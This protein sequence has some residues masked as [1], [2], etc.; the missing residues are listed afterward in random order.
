MRRR[1]RPLEAL[2]A[3]VGLQVFQVLVQI[4]FAYSF[5][6]KE[7]VYRYVW[8][9]ISI[10]SLICVLDVNIVL[11]LSESFLRRLLQNWLATGQG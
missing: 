10:L 9:E 4:N 6:S 2:R 3:V 1:R 7:Q 11:A 8:V 5:S